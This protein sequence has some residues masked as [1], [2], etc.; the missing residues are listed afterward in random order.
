MYPKNK[1]EWKEKCT[2]EYVNK[3]IEAFSKVGPSEK[4]GI[5]TTEIDF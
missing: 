3:K 2:I 1:S 4:T 5:S